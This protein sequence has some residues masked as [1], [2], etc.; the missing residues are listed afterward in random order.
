MYFFIFASDMYISESS[1]AVISGDGSYMPSQLGVLAQISSGGTMMDAFLVQEHITSLDM[2]ERIEKRLD[3]R[4]HY[5]DASRDVISRLRR[6]P[7]REQAL[8]YW[9]WI[10]SAAFEL[11]RGIIFVEVRAYTPEMARAV[12]NAILQC[13]EELVNEM[14]SRAHQDAIRLSQAEVSLAEK[15]LEKAQLALQQFRDDKSVVDPKLTVENL[16]GVIARLEGEAALT[17]AE[18]GAALSLMREDS[19]RVLNIKTRLQ[20]LHEQLRTERSRLSG[21]ARDGTISALLGN[22]AQLTTEEQFAREQ[23]LAAMTALEQARIRSFTQTRYIVPLQPPTR[24]EESLYP[25]PVLFT[26]VAFL[27]LLIL[28]GMCSLLIAAIKDHMGV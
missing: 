12:N 23:L 22:Y 25:R 5:A 20:A 26:I 4:A 10:V 9:R 28:L 15:R 2:L 19:L 6:S 14:N 3:L 21:L 18:L 13:S 11:D 27:G 24:P 8:D 7:T 16:E 1:F 17:E